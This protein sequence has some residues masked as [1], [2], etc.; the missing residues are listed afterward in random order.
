[1]GKIVDARLTTPD[2]LRREPDTVPVAVATAENIPVDTMPK[3]LQSKIDDYRRRDR[4]GWFELAI[5]ERRVKKKEFYRTC[6]K[7]MV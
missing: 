7:M 4:D 6:R 5:S 2:K 1:M 3:Q